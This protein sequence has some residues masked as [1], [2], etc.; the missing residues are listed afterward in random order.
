M[1]P[2]VTCEDPPLADDRAAIE[3]MIR[4]RDITR[5]LHFS[6][7]RGLVGTLA[8]RALK[9]RALLNSDN[10]LE[11]IFTPNAR[12]RQDFPWTRHVSLSISRINAS[13]FAASTRW[14]AR[15]DLWWCVLEFTP[16]LL[17]HEGVVFVTTNNIYTGAD[18]NT[19]AAGLQALFA[20]RI[21]QYR[22]LIS[23]RGPDV[24]D[25]LTT[26]AQAEVLYPVEVCTHHLRRVY[27]Q[28]EDHAAVAEAQMAAVDHPPIPVD[29]QPEAFAATAISW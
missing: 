5:L 18:R 21:L 4:H 10:Y 6:T 16:A 24:P 15:E 27:V 29:V 20:E 22:N 8:S 25:Q 7:N 3:A 19:G 28:S 26:D 13:F 14:H 2:K 11:R 23:V 9:S 17:T 12:V 1:E